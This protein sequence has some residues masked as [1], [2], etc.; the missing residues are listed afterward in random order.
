MNASTRPAR[1][2]VTDPGWLTAA[3]I[4]IDLALAG[5][6]VLFA[7]SL[8]SSETVHVPGS[9]WWCLAAVLA[10]LG[11]LALSGLAM[12]YLWP[13]VRDAPDPPVAPDDDYTAFIEDAQ[14]AYRA[15]FP[16]SGS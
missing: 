13:N 15:R 2:T 5:S 8:A 6:M 1:A 12:T 9:G 10:L 11:R 7:A 3:K 14:A 4:V 16:A